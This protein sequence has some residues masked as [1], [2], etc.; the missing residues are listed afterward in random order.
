MSSIRDAQGYPLQSI[1][2]VPE[3][4]PPPR[5]PPLPDLVRL[6]QEA[7]QREGTTHRRAEHWHRDDIL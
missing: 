7:R 6:L 2:V 3:R 1:D 5:N 4:P